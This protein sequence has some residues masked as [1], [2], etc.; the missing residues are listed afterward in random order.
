MSEIQTDTVCSSTFA[1]LIRKLKFVDVRWIVRHH[2]SPCDHRL[3][4]SASP[5]LAATGFVNGKGQFS[6]PHSIDTPQPITKKFVTGDYVGDPYG[7]AKLGVYPSTG[8]FWAYGWNITKII[9]IYAPFFRNSP[10]G[11][12]CRRIF[13]HDGSNDAVSRKNVL[14]WEFFTLLLI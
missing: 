4:G 9:F 2:A 10:T 1:N 7:W 12:T 8:G 14:F 5:V 13:T 6:T 11:Q 3:R